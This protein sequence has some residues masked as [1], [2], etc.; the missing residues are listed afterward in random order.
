MGPDRQR[1]DWPAPGV[2]IIRIVLESREGNRA[3][4]DTIRLLFPAVIKMTRHAVVLLLLSLGL[5]SCQ[6]KP[7]QLMQG[8]AEGE[9]IL[10]SS[11][12]GG[13]LE[14]LEVQQGQQVAADA[15]L[16]SLE[17]SLEKAVVTA[18]EQEVQGA[19]NRWEDL[20]KGER[21][22]ELKSLASRLEKANADLDLASKEFSRRQR[23]A[24]KQVIP[25]QELDRAQA[26]LSGSQ[27][28]V[29]ELQAQYATA[30][31]GA[32][33]GTIAA[34][35]AELAA[36]QARLEQA[37]WGVAQK[38]QRALQGALVYDTLFEPG[39]YVP[40]GS[41]VVSL[42]PADHIKLRFFIPEPLLG[43]ITLGQQVSVTFDGS[44]GPLPATISFISPK[45]EYTPPVIYSRE[46]RSK[47]VFMIEARP[48]P[49]VATRLHPGQPVD[50][51]LQ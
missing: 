11:P 42:L 1:I 28:R 51:R 36:A 10:V 26:T 25:T 39:E 19:K 4:M 38:T 49:A 16:F 34:A 48:D 37:R 17:D 50:I 29:E 27:A 8:Y 5:C 20:R 3:N 44:N 35:Q 2:K 33:S 21:P 30:Q 22:S 47:L 24:E 13:R 41:P 32:R 43:T 18:A 15:L 23:L 46:T 31:L 14:T 40:A 7:E 9:F 12:L 45:V 6:E